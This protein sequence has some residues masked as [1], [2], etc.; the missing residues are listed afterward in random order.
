MEMGNRKNPDF[1]V[2]YRFFSIEEGGRK[3]G[4]PF[5]GYRCDF[6]YENDDPQKDAIF[7]IWPEFEDSH[8]NI[9][10]ENKC[11]VPVEG[12][13]R[14]WILNS[15]LRAEHRRRIKPGVKAFF[16]EGTK[17]VASLEVIKVVSLADQ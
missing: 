12:T 7:M 2:K 13:A 8:G 16:I 11:H 17:K 14:M 5:Q 6:L 15:D 10:L 1:I 4:T 3:T 9:I